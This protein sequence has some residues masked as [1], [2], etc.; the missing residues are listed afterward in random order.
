MPSFT[1]F[2]L[3]IL[4][5]KRANV[6]ATICRFNDEK[7]EIKQN[8]SLTSFLFNWNITSKT[9]KWRTNNEGKQIEIWIS[10]LLNKNLIPLY[11]YWP[12][13]PSVECYASLFTGP[14][15]KTY[16]SVYPFCTQKIIQVFLENKVRRTSNWTKELK[17]QIKCEE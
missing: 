13:L 5:R 15:I 14:T 16:K 10:W 17:K 3:I 4:H 6:K 8:S 12:R 1:Y 9:F 11:P 2:P 7:F